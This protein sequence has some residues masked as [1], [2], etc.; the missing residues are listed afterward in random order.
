MSEDIFSVF[1]TGTTQGPGASNIPMRVQSYAQGAHGDVAM[2]GLRLDTGEPATIRL[3]DLDNRDFSIAEKQGDWPAGS[4]VAVDGALPDHD[5]GEGNYRARWINRM[6][7]PD[8]QG[9]VRFGMARCFYDVRDTNSQFKNKM[10]VLGQPRA[11]ATADEITTQAVRMAKAASQIGM[12][13]PKVAIT[14]RAPDGAQGFMRTWSVATAGQPGAKTIADD[15]A[16]LAHFQSAAFQRLVA[17]TADL[18]ESKGVTVA[19]HPAVSVGFGKKRAEELEKFRAIMP[20]NISDRRE[21]LKNDNTVNEITRF[22]IDDTG[23]HQF[24]PCYLGFQQDQRI[25]V[26][27]RQLSS[28]GPYHSIADMP[29]LSGEKMSA[30]HAADQFNVRNTAPPTHAQLR[31]P[32]EQGATAVSQAA[33]AQPAPAQAAPP[34]AQPMQAP[35]QQAAQPQQPAPAAQGPQPVA[36]PQPAAPAALPAD[37]ND[38]GAGLAQQPGTP[39]QPAQAEHAA[40][41]PPPVVPAPLPA[42]VDDLAGDLPMDDDIEAQL[43]Q[44]AMHFASHAPEAPA[45]DPHPSTMSPAQG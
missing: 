8:Q 41:P 10:E 6:A 20:E 19:V 22:P 32:V 27:V 5:H 25:L 17:T 9:S 18:I 15:Q 12:G 29:V 26:A 11:V 36:A 45:E 38:L 23:E 30:I 1:T 40:S 39:Q 4:I 14:M 33:P 13:W 21:F 31:G 16:Q 24:T 7:K 42:D 3:A 28:R 34:V 35:Q 2:T 43:S 44:A 37:V